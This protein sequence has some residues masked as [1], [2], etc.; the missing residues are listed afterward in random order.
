MD[1]HRTKF[2]QRNYPPPVKTVG[3]TAVVVGA[4]VVAIAIGLFSY[5]YWW[6][7]DFLGWVK[8]CV[9]IKKP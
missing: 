8:F 7:C 9:S 6:D 2:E 5:T 1:K 3:P 4:L